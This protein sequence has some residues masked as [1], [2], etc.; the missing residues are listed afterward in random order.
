MLAAGE[1]LKFFGSWNNLDL[2]TP[3]IYYQNYEFPFIYE[4]D[5]DQL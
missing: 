3:T 1:S 5:L 4:N 2:V